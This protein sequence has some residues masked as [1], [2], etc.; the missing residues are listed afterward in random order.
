MTLSIMAEHCYVD[1]H[2]A[3]CCYPECRYAECR[4]AI[5][6]RGYLGYFQWLAGVLAEQGWY[7]PHRRNLKIWL[8]V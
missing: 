8:L 7:S 1:C 3:E 4:G 6:S 5:I 2:Y